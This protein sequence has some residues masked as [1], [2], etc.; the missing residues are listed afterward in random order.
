VRER[1]RERERELG[2]IKYE[3]WIEGNVTMISQKDRRIK[4]TEQLGEYDRGNMQITKTPKL[5]K[6]CAMKKWCWK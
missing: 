2:A 3:S 1:E 4:K 6:M 5:N